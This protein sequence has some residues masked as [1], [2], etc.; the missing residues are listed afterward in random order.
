MAAINSAVAICNLALDFIGQASNIA[1]ITAP[2]TDIED[3]MARHYD[4]CRQETLRMNPWHFATKTAMATR[5]GTPLTDYLDQYAFPSDLVRFLSIGG[6]IEEWQFD[7]YR[8]EGN[9]IL[10]NSAFNNTF[11]APGQPTEI[12]RYVY[13]CTDITLWPASVAKL[14]AYILAKDVAYKITKQED[15]VAR[16]A[17]EIAAI[18]PETIAVAGQENPPKRIETSRSITKR[19]FEL[20]SALVA[21]KW[22][23]TP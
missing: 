2:T 18:L 23:I 7:N 21:S 5:I 9:T 15:V 1:S 13:D 3:L 4:I 6:Q 14:F 8:I 20:D 22:T 17:K 12:I 10:I 19:R 11:T 16:L